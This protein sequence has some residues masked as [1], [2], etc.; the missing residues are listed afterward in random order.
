MAYPLSDNSP[1]QNERNFKLQ[2]PLYSVFL[3]RL[4]HPLQTVRIVTGLPQ[5]DSCRTEGMDY[6][7][8]GWYSYY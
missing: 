2:C 1:R 7:V 5:H 3:V 6:V 4:V 8:K